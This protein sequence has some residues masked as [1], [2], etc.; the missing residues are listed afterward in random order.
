MTDFEDTVTAE[1]MIENTARLARRHLVTFVT[2]RDPH[3]DETIR[4]VPMSVKDVY[5]SVVA[6]DLVTERDLVLQRLRRIG[7]FCIDARPGE[8]S[9]RLVNRYLEVKRRELVG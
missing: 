7:V 4:A 9:S 8:I 3:L 6:D 2:L 1:L 5:R